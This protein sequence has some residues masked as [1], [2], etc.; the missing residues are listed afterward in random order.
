MRSYHLLFYGVV[1]LLPIWVVFDD[2]CS[3]LIGVNG[4]YR[5]KDDEVS[6]G[7]TDDKSVS[8]RVKGEN[9]N[10]GVDYENPEECW[11]FRDEH[12]QNAEKSCCQIAKSNDDVPESLKNVVEIK[13]DGM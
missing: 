11:A 6:K 7:V 10:A 13:E 1:F 12:Y 9:E 2:E 5:Y 4:K 8:C 3:G